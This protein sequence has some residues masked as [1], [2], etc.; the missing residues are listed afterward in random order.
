MTADEVSNATG[1]GRASVGQQDTLQAP[2]E[3][4]RV[5]KAERGY[6]MPNPD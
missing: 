5:A 1:L 3:A 6:R 4:D 2:Q